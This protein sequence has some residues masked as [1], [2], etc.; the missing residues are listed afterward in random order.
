ME[1]EKIRRWGDFT[2]L[3]FLTSAD[4][5]RFPSS[6]AVSETISDGGLEYLIRIS[7][8]G[9]IGSFGRIARLLMAWLIRWT[10]GE[11]V[12]SMDIYSVA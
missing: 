12:S 5:M 3:P 11:Y 2:N 10:M 6:W 1:C 9:M 7:A 8:G 4:L